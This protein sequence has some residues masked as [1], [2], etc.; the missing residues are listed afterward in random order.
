MLYDKKTFTVT[1]GKPVKIIFSN[2]DKMPHNLLIVKPG[3]SQKVGILAAQLGE[4]GF[5]MEW[6]PESKDILHGTTMVNP[7]ETA[8]F[9]FT[10]PTKPGDYEYVCTFPGH[11]ILMR[12]VMKVVK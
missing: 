11:W 5:K 7:N 6:R 8:T 9:T 2:P 4:K 3:T 1:A 12:G 10:A